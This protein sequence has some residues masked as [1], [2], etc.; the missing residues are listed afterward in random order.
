M[1]AAGLAVPPRAHAQQ[2]DHEFQE[3]QNCPMMVGIPAGSFVMGSPVGE[4][5]RFDTEGP[6]H[7]VSIK[8]FAL[9][10]YDVTSREFTATVVAIRSKL[11]H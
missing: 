3:C 11:D 7:D 6:Q 9:S 5:G 1:V 2:T 4:Q 8:A 10:K